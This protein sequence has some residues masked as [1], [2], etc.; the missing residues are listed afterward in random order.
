MSQTDKVPN[1]SNFLAQRSN[2]ESFLATQSKAYN[3][4]LSDLKDMEALRED[5][6]VSIKDIKPLDLTKD[7]E[8][9]IEFDEKEYTLNDQ[10]IGQ[11][12][13]KRSKA[14]FSKAYAYSL[15]ETETIKDVTGEPVEVYLK[16]VL[17]REAM[18]T[19][20]LAKTVFREV[21]NMEDFSKTVKGVVGANYPLDFQNSEVLDHIYKKSVDLGLNPR[22]CHFDE[23]DTRAI[24]VSFMFDHPDF[25]FENAKAKEIFG[26]FWKNSEFGD[27]AAGGGAYVYTELC[28]NGMMGWK[29]RHAFKVNHMTRNSFIKNLLL[30]INSFRKRKE[31]ELFSKEYGIDNNWMNPETTYTNFDKIYP[32]IAI[33]I[34]FRSI[35]GSRYLKKSYEK[36]MK[37]VVA[38]WKKELAAQIKKH[39][40]GKTKIET[41]ETLAFQDKTISLDE[42]HGS[43]YDLSTLLT[44]AGNLYE[45]HYSENF[46]ES[47][48]QVI[49]GK[50]L[51]PLLKVT[52]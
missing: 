50:N 35:I 49:T 14:A 43:L 38:D 5:T 19:R 46:Q 15:P 28:T 10:A 22:P 47:A 52:H 8:W 3:T 17:F 31:F 11:L 16:D 26:A 20:P 48:M 18:S 34:I 30:K 40:L 25:V 21:T 6:M 29:S 39:S 13:A 2:S 36:A 42:K 44:S 27:E 24:R 9:K 7:G 37:I 23:R 32:E 4:F 41:L 1:V 12:G 33:G 45:G 51:T